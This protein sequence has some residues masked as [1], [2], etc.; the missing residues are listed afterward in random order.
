[1][2]CE[3]ICWVGLPVRFLRFFFKIKKTWPF[4]FFW[5]A[6]H[7]FSNTGCGWKLIGCRDGPCCGCCWLLPTSIGNKWK[8]SSGFLDLLSLLL[9]TSS[10]VVAGHEI[11][12]AGTS[13]TLSSAFATMSDFFMHYL[14]LIYLHFFSPT[15][16]TMHPLTLLIL[17]TYIY[18]Y[19][20]NRHNFFT[21]ICT[22]RRFFSFSLLLS[23]PRPV[24]FQL[25]C[26]LW[27]CLL[28]LPRLVLHHIPLWQLVREKYFRWNNICIL[29]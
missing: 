27:Y 4:T 17:L 12:D 20:R 25:C 29:N 15:P 2:A 5:V 6:S 23:F 22:V 19:T 9:V 14:N 24:T 8:I 16:L 1:V 13:S 7:V 18:R 11:L 3:A 10:A 26:R 21:L 28:V